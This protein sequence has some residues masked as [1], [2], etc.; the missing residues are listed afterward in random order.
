MIW[1]TI[2]VGLIIL[3]AVYFAA[4]SFIRTMS[5]KDE[6][7]CGTCPKRDSCPP[8]DQDIDPPDFPEC[9]KAEFQEKPREDKADS[10][11]ESG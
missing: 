8:L 1:E 2:L 9:M 5:G 10:T 11:P 6:S 7:A 3:V 4:R